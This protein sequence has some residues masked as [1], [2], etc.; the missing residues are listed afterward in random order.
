MDHLDEHTMAFYAMGADIPS[1]ERGAIEAHLRDCHGCRAQVEEFRGIDEHVAEAIDS[2]EQTEDLPSDALVAL[3]KAIRRRPNAPPVRLEP[4]SVTRRARFASLVRRHPLRAGSAGLVLGFLAF[5]LISTASHRARKVDQPLF[6]RLNLLGTAMEVYGKDTE[7]FEIPVSAM[8][9]PEPSRER[10][11]K[12]CTQIA[13]LDGDGN[14]E[15]ITGFPYRENGTQKANVLRVFSNDG[16]LL[17]SWPLGGVPL[18]YNGVNYSGSRSVS[19][20]VVTTGVGTGEKELL[21][22]LNN[23]RSPWCLMRLDSKGRTFGEYWH[24]GWLWGLTTVH[25]PGVNH[26]LILLTGVNDEAYRSNNGYPMITVLDPARINGSTESECTRGFGFPA[27]DAQ[28]Y[29]IKSGNV[30]PA[31]ISGPRVE[32]PSFGYDVKIGADSS[33]VVREGFSFPSDFPAILYTFDKQLVLK[34]VWMSDGPRITLLDRFLAQKTPQGFDEF[35][36]DLK[37][38]VRYWDGSQWR[39]E[40]S[41]IIHFSPPS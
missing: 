10:Q 23:D 2:A 9:D 30:N 12:F 19:G 41:K 39:K 7:L 37:G 40:P 1:P 31:L 36:N 11:T 14:M 35:M 5:F 29:Y 17:Y 20:L 24:F 25:L 13:D 16:Q 26:E 8:A 32:S 27:S 3:P 33:V 18:R 15:V 21:V 4:R 6:V 28:L 34:D 38:K 22:G